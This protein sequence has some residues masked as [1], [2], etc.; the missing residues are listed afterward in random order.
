MLN[1]PFCPIKQ[2]LRKKQSEVS[3]V[4]I[5]QHKVTNIGW[6]LSLGASPLP[7]ATQSLI[8]N[9]RSIRWH[10]FP[11]IICIGVHQTHTSIR[12]WFTN[13]SICIHRA[14][15]WKFMMILAT[16]GWVTVYSG[17]ERVS[18]TIMSYVFF[19]SINIIP[20]IFLLTNAES[21]MGRTGIIVSGGARER[22]D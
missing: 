6:L 5:P 13:C 19:I 16:A 20:A 17:V 21:S 12:C 22:F 4:K 14:C 7:A 8:R 3:M 2:K 10:I 15:N 18:S 9:Y 11:D 1:A